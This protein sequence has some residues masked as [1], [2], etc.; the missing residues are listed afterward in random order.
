VRQGLDEA[1]SDTAAVPGKK[2]GTSP[3]DVLTN[4]YHRGEW[5]RQGMLRPK[6]QSEG[7]F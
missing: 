5:Q 2:S 7:G 3:A 4:Y 6:F 1:A